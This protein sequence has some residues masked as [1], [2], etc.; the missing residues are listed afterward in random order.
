MQVQPIYYSV[1]EHMCR[2][3]LQPVSRSMMNEVTSFG[4]EC[5]D[6]E[7]KRAQKV[8]KFDERDFR[9]THIFNGVTLTIVFAILLFLLALA[10]L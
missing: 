7:L 1:S 5:N 9:E 10:G 8:L 6:I 2:N 3:V 4:K